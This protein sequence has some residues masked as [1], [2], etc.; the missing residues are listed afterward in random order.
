MRGMSFLVVLVSAL[1]AI[2]SAAPST[3]APYAARGSASRPVLFGAGLVST[4]HD[5]AHVSFSPDGRT[6]YFLRDS[7]D[8]ANWTVLV[9]RFDGQ[10][11]SPPEVAPFSGRWND[12]DVTVTR[13]GGRIFFISNR[14]TDGGSASRPDTELWT[15][16]RTERGWSEPRHL[17]ELSSP[18]DEWFPTLTDEGTVYFGSERAGGKGQCDLW[19]ARW[20]GDHFGAPENLG[21]EINTAGQ[22]IEPWISPDEHLLLFSAKGRPD[23]Q[24]EYDLYSSFRCGGRWTPPRPLGAG[25]NSPGW[26][27]GGRVSPDGKYLFFTSNRSTFREPGGRLDLKELT[28]RLDAPGNGLRDVYQIEM[29]ALQLVDPCPR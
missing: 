4:G 2:A 27:F 7:P 28:R 12:G 22:E 17:A 10:R 6:M 23:S 25:V 24:G 5:D 13:D 16:E 8:F 19:R 14:P 29:Q 1:L 15:M 21:E 26:E 11:W 20:L 9:S 3:P 18:G